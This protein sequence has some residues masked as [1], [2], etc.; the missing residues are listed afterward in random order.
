MLMIFLFIISAIISVIAANRL[1]AYA[2][3][4]SRETKIGGMT[5]G[6]VLLAIATSLPELTA[7]I[8]ASVIGNA[9]I[10][11][12]NG[13]GSILFNM[14]A[15]FVLDLHF[16][17][18]KLFLHVDNSHKNT[19]VISLLLCAMAAVFLWWDVQGEI[20]RFSWLSIVMILTY[21]IGTWLISK[22]Q[23][24]EAESEEVNTEA[25][26]QKSVK[27][28]VLWFLFF[29]AVIFVSGS[30]LSI[31]GDQIAQATGI[32]ATAVGSILI[33]L[34]TSLPDGV[35]VYTALK[36]GNVNLAV[37]AILG[38]NMFNVFVIPLSDFFY[39]NGSIWAAAGDQNIMIAI[40]GF[41]LTVIVMIVL[42]RCKARNTFYYILP[43]LTAVISYIA[44]IT[45]ILF[46]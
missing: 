8:S 43:S 7:S 45:V 28:T 1:S 19:G 25:K 9:E 11:V 24:K 35:S 13:L 37:G 6:M 15:L 36:L 31:T 44:I 30:A 29:S 18:K 4:I 39:V 23:K 33:A 10:V 3:I 42:M 27:P 14:F 20:F 26:R 2:D 32:S 22:Q 12:G 46:N 17:R 16:R 21:F 41:V 34:T 38:S 40:A 5:A